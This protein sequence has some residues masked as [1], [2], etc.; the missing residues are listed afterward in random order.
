MVR[1]FMKTFLPFFLIISLSYSALS[2]PLYK[3]SMK[4]NSWEILV[5]DQTTSEITEES[6][7]EIISTI[8]AI[9]LEEFKK[10][11]RVTDL[12]TD[13]QTP[14]FSA[15]ATFKEGR[16]GINFWG[17]MARLDGTTYESFAFI[18]CHEVGHIIGGKPYSSSADNWASAEGQ[19]DAFSASICLK[20]F[21]KM[22]PEKRAQYPIDKSLK[23]ACNKRYDSYANQ[24]L[25]QRI[26]YA[27]EGFK[28]ALEFMYTEVQN[29]S[30][31]TPDK[32]IVDTT[33]TASYPSAQCRL[34]TI[35][36]S[37]FNLNDSNDL[38]MSRPACW[39][40]K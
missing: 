39:Y 21:F 6:F 12:F 16:F 20:K 33:V 31:L 11:D 10:H 27:G 36:A 17:G 25:C 7:H 1:K 15:W 8:Y 35:K 30:Y 24:R 23:K 37:A 14:Y 32:T 2:C 26:L 40:A 3:D 29:L 19:A 4:R 22:M 34:D 18:A 5:G 28:M 9:Y 13:W 38:T